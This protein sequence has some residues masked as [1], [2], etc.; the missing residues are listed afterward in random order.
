MRRLY[1]T[2]PAQGRLSYSGKS[3]KNLLDILSLSLSRAAF[4]GSVL[5]TNWSWRRSQV[6]QSSIT[7]AV[8][9]VSH[10]Q[11][12]QTTN[13]SLSQLYTINWESDQLISS[14]KGDTAWFEHAKTLTQSQLGWLIWNWAQESGKFIKHLNL[15]KILFLVQFADCKSIFQQTNQISNWFLEWARQFDAKFYTFIWIK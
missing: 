14:A 11:L 13:H 2:K 10:Q 1:S 6:W 9:A 15:S 7:A 5:D 12:S 8:W 4:C 3:E